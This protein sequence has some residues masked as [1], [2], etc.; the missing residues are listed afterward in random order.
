MSGT[1][2]CDFRPGDLVRSIV[3]DDQKLGTVTDITV[4]K[5][6]SPQVSTTNITIRMWPIIHVMWSDGSFEKMTNSSIEHIEDDEE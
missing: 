2:Y 4:K 5:N 3:Y 1:F 6:S